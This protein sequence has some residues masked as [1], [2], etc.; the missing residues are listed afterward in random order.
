MEKFEIQ[1]VDQ[2]LEVRPL[3]N[4]SFEMYEAD[5]YLGTVTPRINDNGV[6]WEPSGDIGN[7]F[8]QQIGELIEE[9]DM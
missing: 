9:H 3:E 8:A 4:G 1:L 5:K 6:I 2:T 7:D